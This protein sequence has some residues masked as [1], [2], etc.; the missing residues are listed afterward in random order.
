MARRDCD[1]S[2]KHP[3]FKRSALRKDHDKAHPRSLVDYI[4]GLDE[5]SESRLCQMRRRGG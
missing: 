2:H 1:K 3:A 4:H 5:V